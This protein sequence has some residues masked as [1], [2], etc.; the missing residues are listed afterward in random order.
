MW[1][2]LIV[3]DGA[4][5]RRTS[6]SPI[7]HPRQYKQTKPYDRSRMSLLAKPVFPA[8]GLAAHLVL[9][10]WLRRCAPVT[11]QDQGLRALRRLAPGCLGSPRK[12]SVPHRVQLRRSA[13][14]TAQVYGFARVQSN[15]LW[16]T[17]RAQQTPCESGRDRHAACNQVS[18][19]YQPLGGTAAA[20][21]SQPLSQPDPAIASTLHGP[22]DR[23]GGCAPAYLKANSWRVRRHGRRWQLQG[24]E[25]RVGSGT[26]CDA[27]ANPNIVGSSRLPA[28][29]V[30]QVGVQPVSQRHSG[31]RCPALSARLQYLGYKLCAVLATHHSLRFHSV[32]LVVSWT[33]C[34]PALQRGSR[35]GG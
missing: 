22:V 27:I 9:N 10:H 21:S 18:W 12:P 19:F 4:G 8:S 30:N 5:H 28:P 25:L 11:H 2:V 33:L 15:P 7:S 3:E 29:A 1:R 14:L 23:D 16:L 32:H 26:H 6:G 13:K 34:L 17:V 35:W 31:N 20:E 24:H